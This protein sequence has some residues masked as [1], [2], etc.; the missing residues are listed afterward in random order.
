MDDLL[1]L[2]D[3]GVTIEF[4]ASITLPIPGHAR[5]SEVVEAIYK[6]GPKRC[7]LSSDAG[8]SVFPIASEALR[9]YVQCLADTGLADDDARQM[10]VDNPRKVLGV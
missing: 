5:P 1:K 8:A 3:M 2:A 7:V 6:I 4:A 10:M 9:S